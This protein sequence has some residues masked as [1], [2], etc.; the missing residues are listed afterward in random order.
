MI[1]RVI[2]IL[3][4]RILMPINLSRNV[5]GGWKL[6]EFFKYKPCIKYFKLIYWVTDSKLKVCVKFKLWFFFNGMIKALCKIRKI[7]A[8]LNSSYWFCVLSQIFFNLF[9]SQ[10]AMLQQDVSF[11]LPKMFIIVQYCHYDRKGEGN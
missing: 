4:F 8:V 7:Q 11:Q 2:G 10:F 5:G 6:S 3:Y 1:I 9:L